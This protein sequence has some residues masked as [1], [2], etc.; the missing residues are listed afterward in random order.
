MVPVP[1]LKI[2][3]LEFYGDLMEFHER[4]EVKRKKVHLNLAPEKLWKPLSHV[5]QNNNNIKHK[6]RELWHYKTQI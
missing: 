4:L 2:I 3:I 1:L 5:I 6:K